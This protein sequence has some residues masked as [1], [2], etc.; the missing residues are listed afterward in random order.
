MTISA[1]D[2]RVLSPSL[3]LQATLQARQHFPL[4]IPYYFE[5]DM[6]FN[7]GHIQFLHVGFRE[8][9]RKVHIPRI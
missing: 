5:Y 4:K 3:H 1:E 8:E 6:P 9:I 2:N 7:L